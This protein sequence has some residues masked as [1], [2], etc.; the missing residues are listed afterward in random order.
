MATERVITYKEFN[1][2]QERENLWLL[3][4]GKGTLYTSEFSLLPHL[5]IA[6]MHVCLVPPY[7]SSHC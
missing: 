7:T 1:Q 6:C 2:H 5:E 3:L 4:H